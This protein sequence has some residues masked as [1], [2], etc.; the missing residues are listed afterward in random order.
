MNTVATTSQTGRPAKPHKPVICIFGLG[1]V[2]LTM[3]VIFAE[4][5]YHVIGVEPRKRGIG[6]LLKGQ[7]Y[8]HEKGLKELLK[9]HLGKRLTIYKE[10]DHVSADVYVV[11]VGTPVSNDTK[12][13]DLGFVKTV[14]QS[15]GK[16][17]K[18]G[19]LVILRSTVP[20]GTSRN[21]LIPIIEK[22]S[23]LT[24]GEDFY[25]A[26][27]PE[28]VVEGN[29][30]KELRLI[31]QIIGGFDQTSLTKTTELFKPVVSKIIP[32]STLESAELVKL[33]NNTFRDVLFGFANELA[34]ICDGFNID[35]AEVVRAA[36]EDY[37]RSHIPSPSPGVGGYCLTKDPF[38]LLYST[39]NHPHHP[40]I[41]F[42][43]RKVNEKMT[44]H[45]ADRLLNFLSAIGRPPRQARIG[46][47][48]FAFKGHPETADI[49]FSPTMEVVDFLRRHRIQLI[50]HDPIVA[51][52]IIRAHGVRPV[53]NVA[54]A[55]DGTDGVVIMTNHLRYRNA[56][57][58]KF[59]EK[60]RRPGIFFDPWHLFAPHKV[61]QHEGLHYSNLGF[62]THINSANNH[63]VKSK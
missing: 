62:S 10:P 19:D 17:I 46:I 15:I 2:G 21:L 47:L 20:V 22:S 4:S 31:P 37:L 39:R 41:V 23:G 57:L 49:R 33:F 48:G 9:K 6:Q 3:S 25:V 30:L 7:P 42:H 28:R 27:T 43:G 13:P 14:A 59:A 26:F 52:S 55:F 5:G 16:I 63:F 32:V 11:A 61:L 18:R 29:A 24:V 12:S 8:F 45:V 40:D 56:D 51:S 50:G 58:L 44:R 34:L 53:K 1:Y 38:I 54:D 60:M 35:P 36:N